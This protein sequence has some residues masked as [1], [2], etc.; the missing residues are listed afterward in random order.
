MKNTFLL[1]EHI[2]KRIKLRRSILGLSQKDLAE[3]VGVSFQQI[4][5]YEQG[6]NRVSASRLYDISQRLQVDVSF[7]F[8]NLEN[9]T[10]NTLQS[11]VNNISNTNISSEKELLDCPE[12]DPMSRN[13]TLEL[14]RNYW[15][16]SSTV[17]RKRLLEL[18][19]VLSNA[20]D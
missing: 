4:Q 8:Q 10:N 18:I 3:T 1:D 2:G 14:V 6:K 13:E 16:I 17:C 15:R 19:R 20:P 5:K 9:N 11:D 12:G 7:F